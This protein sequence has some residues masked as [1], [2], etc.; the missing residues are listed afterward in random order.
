MG[1]LALLALIVIFVLPE[2]VNQYELPLERRVD[3]TPPLP[4]S[5][6]GTQAVTVSPFAEA[7]LANQRKQAQDVL[8]ELLGIQAELETLEIERWAPA[9]YQAALEQAATADEHY[10]TQ[11]FEQARVSYSNSVEAMTQLRDSVPEVLAQLLAAGENALNTGDAELAAEQFTM[12][13]VIDANNANARTGLARAQVLDE[14]N[15]LLAQAERQ[16]RNN[17]LEQARDSLEAAYDLD[18]TNTETGTRL[19][20]INRQIR[21]AE[22]ARVMSSGYTLLEGGDPAAAIATFRRAANLGVNPAQARA[23]ITQTEA[24][25]ETARIN[26]L[27]D[28][29]TEAETQ[30]RWPDAVTAYDE[31]LAIDPN[32]SFAIQGRDYADKRTNLDQLLVEAIAN[33]TRLSEDAVYQQT[34][35]VYRTGRALQPPGP[36]LQSQL[37]ELQGLL[38]TSQIPVDINL[39]SDNLTTVTLLRTAELGLFEQTRLSLKPGNYTAIGRRE[40]FREV[41]VEFTVGYGQTPSQVVVQCVEPVP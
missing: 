23:A 37:D 41:R 5:S 6:D 15:A 13:Q 33:P 24:N 10:R 11:D 4:Q 31:V 35:D 21:E 1:V 18:A 16:T 29:I 14:V 27:Q 36:R 28:A 32:L 19:N 25:L 3:V 2:V 38:E 40:G 30:E 9:P 34:L 8:A 39:L 20:A 26:E 17:E 12:A 22:F 7:Q